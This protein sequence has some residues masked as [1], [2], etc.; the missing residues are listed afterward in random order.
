M[1]RDTPRS[2]AYDALTLGLS[3]SAIAG[4]HD[5]ELSTEMRSF[6]YMPFMHSE[7]LMIHQAATELF[8]RLGVTSTIEFEAKYKRIIERFG[9]YP[10]RNN[11]LERVSTEEEEAF[12]QLHNSSF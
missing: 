7:S 4:G 5:D 8:S 11:I 10:H 2:F 3:H 12:L 1:Y 6:L 9:R